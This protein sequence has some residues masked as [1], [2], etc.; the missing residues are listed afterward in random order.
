M[1]RAGKSHLYVVSA[2]RLVGVLSLRDFLEAL[3]LK[4]EIEGGRDRAGPLRPAKRHG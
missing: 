3:T 2:G 1:R 4:L